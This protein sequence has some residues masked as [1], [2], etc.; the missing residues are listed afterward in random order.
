ML[1]KTL[2]HVHAPRHGAARAPS[3]KLLVVT[4]LL[5][6]SS[7]IL[8]GFLYHS[9]RQVGAR[10]VRG[11]AALRCARCLGACRDTGAAQTQLRARARRP[12]LAA[13]ACLA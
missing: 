3:P 5:G 9:H 4:M 7:G 2:L 1:P 12:T 6:F 8:T 13:D 10:F 11:A